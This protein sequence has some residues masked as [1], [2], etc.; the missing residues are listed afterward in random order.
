MLKALVEDMNR[1]GESP[2]EAMEM[3]NAKP[4]YDND[5]G[6]GKFKVDL[7]VDKKPVKE[8]NLYDKFWKS[9]P[10]SHRVITVE[11]ELDEDGDNDDYRTAEFEPTDLRN[12]NGDTGEFLYIN[13]RGDQLKLTRE[14]AQSYDYWKAF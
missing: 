12:I 11:Y 3:L 9:N 6:G 4:E 13:S 10:L 2:Q 5:N 14:R 8:S 1:Y 7:V